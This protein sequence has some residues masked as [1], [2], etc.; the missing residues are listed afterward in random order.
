MTHSIFQ[1]ISGR[2]HDISEDTHWSGFLNATVNHIRQY[3]QPWDEVSKFL[4]TQ[5]I[6][7]NLSS[8][9]HVIAQPVE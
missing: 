1:I 4:F 3:K 8:T 2:Y 5:I 9:G 6:D 7:H